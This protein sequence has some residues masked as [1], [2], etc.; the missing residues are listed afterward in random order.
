MWYFLLGAVGLLLLMACVTVTNLR[1]A[2]ASVRM[3]EMG[4]RFALGA[5]RRRIA[6]QLLVESL[7]LATI[8]GV[9]AVALTYQALPIVQAL[10]PSNIGRLG[11]AGVNGPVLAVALSAALLAVLVSGLAPALLVARSELFDSIRSGSARTGSQGTR[12]RDALVVG[13][14]ALAVTVVLGA[15]LMMRSFVLLQSVDLGFEPE[16]MVRFTVRLPNTR[17]QRGERYP[18]MV[19]LMDEIEAIPGVLAAG[20]THA[21]PFG[22]MAPSNFVA[23]SDQEPD[24][25][26]DFEPVSWRGVAGDYFEALGVPLLDGPAPDPRTIR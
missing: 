2:Q 8:G 1:V 9:V 22:W 25:Q 23:R 21:P 19:Q 5:G 4:V 10:G 18:Q 15:G 16:G 3:Q 24:R 26:Q 7:V 12:L 20:T 11:D 13:Q 14:F 6:L 17:F